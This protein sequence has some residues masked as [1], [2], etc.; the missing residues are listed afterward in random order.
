MK[1]DFATPC[2]SQQ[3]RTADRLNVDYG[4]LRIKV[5]SFRE[6]QQ[7]P[8]HVLQ[9]YFMNQNGQDVATPVVQQ[10]TLGST[11]QQPAGG[12][13]PTQTPTDD[14]THKDLINDAVTAAVSNAANLQSADGLS[15]TVKR[16]SD[17]EPPSQ[18]LQQPLQQQDQSANPDLLQMRQCRSPN[19]I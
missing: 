15:A 8:V 10:P 6:Q 16:L 13:T 12:Q 7:Q 5:N 1:V 18:P 4:S 11:A 19:L 3:L 2:G 14:K 17:Q 9:Q